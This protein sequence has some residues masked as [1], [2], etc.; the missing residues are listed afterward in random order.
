MDMAS[1]SQSMKGTPLPERRDC[2]SAAGGYI[3][4][5]LDPDEKNR[6]YGQVQDHPYTL[7]H[8]HGSVNYD[9]D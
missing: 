6:R 1:H 7:E 5:P 9:Q 3:G 8:N 4:D 2:H